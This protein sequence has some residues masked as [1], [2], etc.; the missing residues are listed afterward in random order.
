MEIKAGKNCFYIGN[1]ENDYIAVITYE[2]LDDNTWNINHTFVD[3]SLEGQG[4]GR[5]LVQAVQTA[6]SERGIK[7]LATCSYA[8]HVLSKSTQK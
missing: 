1:S 7:L 4:I 2:I 3:P 6:A 5:K 8:A